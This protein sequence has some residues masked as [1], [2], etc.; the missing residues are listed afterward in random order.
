MD[1]IKENLVSRGVVL[2]FLFM[3]FAYNDL[4]IRYWFVSLPACLLLFAGAAALAGKSGRK[5]KTKRGRVL[6]IERQSGWITFAEVILTLAGGAT[7]VYLWLEH[8]LARYWYLAVPCA[9]LFVVGAIL[10]PDPAG[11]YGGEGIAG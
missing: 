8:N 1:Q 7:L 11:D 9:A 4:V 6:D 5:R 3:V 2:A 10:L